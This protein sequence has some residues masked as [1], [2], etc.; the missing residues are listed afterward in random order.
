M[1]P[2]IIGNVSLKTWVKIYRRC[3]LCPMATFSFF[4]GLSEVS[5]RVIVR[6]PEDIQAFLEIGRVAQRESTTLT[7]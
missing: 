1:L 4:P 7:S 6:A 5:R 3:V 2:D